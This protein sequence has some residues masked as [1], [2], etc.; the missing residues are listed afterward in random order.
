VPSHNFE[1]KTWFRF[2]PFELL[3]PLTG[4]PSPLGFIEHNRMF[5]W[6]FIS[7]ATQVLLEV[8]VDVLNARPNPPPFVSKP[9]T[10]SCGPNAVN[11]VSRKG[12]PENYNK[13]RIAG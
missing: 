3:G 11:P 12:F 2:F 6:H 10:T 4:I 7:R 9:S 8:I 1:Q 5:V 13:G